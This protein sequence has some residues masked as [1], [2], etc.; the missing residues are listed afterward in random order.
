MQVELLKRQVSGAVMDD[1]SIGGGYVPLTG[2]I[3]RC[4]GRKSH[5]FSSR[6][7]KPK[8]RLVGDIRGGAATAAAPLVDERL[9]GEC[10]PK[11]KHSR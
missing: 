11:D 7:H 5:A 10:W 9:G 1:C 8:N 3:A 4:Q 6:Q 2:G